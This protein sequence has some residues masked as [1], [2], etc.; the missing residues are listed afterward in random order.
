LHHDPGDQTTWLALADALEESGQSDR[1]E[2][3]RLTC[4]LRASPP[5]TVCTK[6]QERVQELLQ[7]GVLPCVPEVVNSIGVRF[8]LIPPGAFLMGLPK[9]E[10]NEEQSPQHEVAIS[11]PFYLGVHPVTQKQWGTIMGDN[12][13]WFSA[14]GGDLDKVQGLNTAD[15]PVERVSW[16]D[17]TRFL[18]KLAARS[19]EASQT[20]QY[21]LPSES[22]WEYSCRGGLPCSTLFHFGNSLS[23][24]QANFNGTRPHGRARRG[25]ALS[26]PCPVGSNPANAFGLFDMHG[27]AWEWC[28]DWGEEKPSTRQEPVTR[29]PSRHTSRVIRGGSWIG[30]GKYCRSAY[31]ASNRPSRQINYVGFRAALVL[32]DSRR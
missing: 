10:E 2:L 1:A 8:V 16:L 13:A 6:E 22:E 17:A 25:P 3:T 14:T 27:N 26:R 4:R 29:K 11:K 24:A 12:P 23:S 30:C 9:G 19:E 15:F 5:G 7:S 18:K 32:P 28:E 21:R 31:R 20:R